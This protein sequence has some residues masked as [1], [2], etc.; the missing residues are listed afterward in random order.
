M[1]QYAE[2]FL[3]AH[4]QETAAAGA[5]ETNRL[6]LIT[7]GRPFYF[8]VN[9]GRAEA[10]SSVAVLSPKGEVRVTF[11]DAYKAVDEVKFEALQDAI[12]SDL[13]EGYFKQVFE[14]SIKSDLIPEAKMQEV[15]D[16]VTQLAVDHGIEAAV[17][18]KTF[19]K[20]TPEWHNARLRL[21]T[22]EVNMKLER[23]VDPEKGFCQVAV[24]PARKGK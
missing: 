4:A 1:A 8:K 13:A 23:A 11:K 21:L 3:E 2:A 15:I 12:G 14:F 10:P 18:V 5:K 7:A 20:P 24:G 22:D 17:A 6:E 16:A 19:Y 9:Q